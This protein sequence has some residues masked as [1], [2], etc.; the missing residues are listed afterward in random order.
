MP[1]FHLRRVA[2]HPAVE[3]RTQ[4]PSL[5]NPLYANLPLGQLQMFHNNARHGEALGVQQSHVVRHNQALLQPVEAAR[6]AT[7]PAWAQHTPRAAF[8]PTV[9]AP[10]AATGKLRQVRRR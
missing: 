3:P 9:H 8:T 1:N 7:L 10:V 6:A 2:F 4:E 5:H